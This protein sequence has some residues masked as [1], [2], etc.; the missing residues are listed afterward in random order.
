MSRKARTIKN[1][2]RSRP[3]R[4]PY[5]RVLIVCE[6]GKTEPNYFQALIDDLQ[7]NTANVEVDGKSGSSPR[8][9]VTYA[10]KRFRQDLALNGSGNSF[11]HVYCVFDKDEHPTHGEALNSIRD[12]KPGNIFQAI[13]SVP[14][15]EFWLLLHFSFTTR[16]IGRSGSRSPGDNTKDELKNYLPSYDKGDK[17]IYQQLKANTATAIKNAAKVLEATN[18]AGTDNPSTLVHTLVEFLQ[19]LGK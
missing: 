8:S 15:F 14:C 16:P 4:S 5:A 17:A 9:V 13:T 6:G 7:L 18:A 2:Q 19:K 11:D 10:K 3:K 12:A 1:L